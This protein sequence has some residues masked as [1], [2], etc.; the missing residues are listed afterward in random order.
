MCKLCW[1]ELKEIFPSTHGWVD[2]LDRN[3]L[4][5]I[6][7][8]CTRNTKDNS[9]AVDLLCEW[10]KAIWKE[11]NSWWELFN[12]R[13]SPYIIVVGSSPTKA[14]VDLRSIIM[15]KHNATTI[16]P[17]FQKQKIESSFSHFHSAHIRASEVIWVF[18]PSARRVASKLSFLTEEILSIHRNFNPFRCLSS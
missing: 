6:T 11:G 1:S 3:P 15:H 13:S 4:N 16:S 10:R 8:S 2:R 18:A 5:L 12:I 14:Q 7:I 17:S 9:R